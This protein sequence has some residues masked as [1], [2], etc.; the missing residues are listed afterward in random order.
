MQTNRFAEISAATLKY[1][2]AKAR[3]AGFVQLSHNFLR[4]AELT[5]VPDNEILAIYELLR[6]GRSTHAELCTTADKLELIYGASETAA[7]VRDAAA[8]YLRRNLFRPQ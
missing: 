1:Q 4:A 3:D 8:E 2:A 7:F 5:V 6:P